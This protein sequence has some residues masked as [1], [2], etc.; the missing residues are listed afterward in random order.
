MTRQVEAYQP[1][2]DLEQML[3]SKRG[4]WVPS[5]I[6]TW[7]RREP[8]PDGYNFIGF[9]T[10]DLTQNYSV[11]EIKPAEVKP[12]DIWRG[13][14]EVP[15][16]TFDKVI[17]T[18]YPALGLITMWKALQ[19][20]LG[21]YE[22]ALVAPTLWK[23]YNVR[24]E[25]VEAER[26]KSAKISHY[27]STRDY[28][29]DFPYVGI[30]MNLKLGETDNDSQVVWEI[31]F[32]QLDEAKTFPNA[33]MVSVTKDKVIITQGKQL[34]ISY[35]TSGA[36]PYELNRAKGMTDE[37]KE[38]WEGYVGAAIYDVLGGAYVSMLQPI[39]V[40]IDGLL[41]HISSELSKGK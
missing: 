2:H 30:D 13:R 29:S 21:Q 18:T 39:E 14:R 19:V 34:L 9:G 4:L 11:M 22:A 3:E 10:A 17:S 5:D 8:A 38:I 31:P 12:L 33:V 37:T 20:N 32:G 1:F 7:N 41:N 26:V 36:T 28:T 16:V 27:V 25:G 40:Y 15:S 35:D 23:M 24:C 6:Y